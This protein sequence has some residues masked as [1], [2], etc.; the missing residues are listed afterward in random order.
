MARSKNIT[1]G[2]TFGALTVLRD[3][4]VI[5]GNRWFQCRCECGV[6]LLRRMD[7]LK[8]GR[9]KSCG[10][11]R[12]GR[13]AASKTEHGHCKLRGSTKE[14]RAWQHM[15]ERCA[16][17]SEA[18]YGGRGISVCDRWAKFSTFIADMGPCPSASHSIDRIDPNGNYE[19]SNCR[20]ATIS[21]QA[22]NKRTVVPVVF[23]GVRGL[24]PDVARATGVKPDYLYAIR[25]KHKLRG[26]LTV[27]AGCHDLGG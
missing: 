25:R 12:F 20:W 22:R 23:R 3:A 19:P 7:W 15:R 26:S 24:I 27:L 6:E 1:P 9:V 5:G 11:Q 17:T 13:L 8:Q 21:E 16:D 10:C 2:E 4:G 14:Y 18:N